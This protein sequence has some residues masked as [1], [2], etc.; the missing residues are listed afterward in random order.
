MIFVSLCL[1]GRKSE[2]M[3]GVQ[4]SFAL[5]VENPVEIRSQFNRHVIASLLES[6]IG[7]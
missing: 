5:A 3:N 6:G 7:P 4:K 2:K 1:C